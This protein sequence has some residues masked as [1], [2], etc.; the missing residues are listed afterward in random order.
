METV[1]SSPEGTEG[2]IC[3][4]TQEAEP[5][6]RINENN[7]LKQRL[8]V[9]KAKLRYCPNPGF[10]MT[11][12]YGITSTVKEMPSSLNFTYTTAWVFLGS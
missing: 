2:S 7:I 9:S 4:L 1:P 5:A 8:I 6:I 3:S 10:N 12:P 11:S